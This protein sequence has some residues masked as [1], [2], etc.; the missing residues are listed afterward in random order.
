MIEQKLLRVEQRPKN[1]L[2]GFFFG[3]EGHVAG[4]AAGFLFQMAAGEFHFVGVRVAAEGDVVEVGDFVVIGAGVLGEHVGAAIA[5]GELGL[6]VG[7]VQQM[8]TLGE[9]GFLGAFAFAGAG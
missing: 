7:G 5:T 3:F 9:A 2:K 8:Q 4:F 6:D 1:V